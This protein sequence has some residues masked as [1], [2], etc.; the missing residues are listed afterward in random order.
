MTAPFV[1]NDRE[2]E[3]EVEVA[4]LAKRRFRKQSSARTGIGATR[5]TLQGRLVLIER[6]EPR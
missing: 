6:F 2:V 5:L 1:P 4:I 3:V